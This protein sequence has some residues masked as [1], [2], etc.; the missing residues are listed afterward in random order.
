ML[1]VEFKC[2]MQA[3][4]GT[5]A[6]GDPSSARLCCPS[7]Q[8]QL[9]AGPAAGALPA[10]LRF[11]NAQAA[12]SHL[13]FW[14]CLLGFRSTSRSHWCSSSS[15]ETRRAAGS[16]GKCHCARKQN[17]CKPEL[18]HCAG[19]GPF[20]LAVAKSLQYE[21]NAHQDALQMILR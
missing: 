17:Y 1:F 12:Q 4:A 3:C 7:C 2:S 9:A 11:A 19:K 8:Q 18:S 15:R 13:V 20:V 6:A 16:A 5:Q 10:R 21:V 14:L